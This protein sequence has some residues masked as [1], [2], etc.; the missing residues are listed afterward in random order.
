MI[1]LDI[2]LPAN[3][4]NKFNIEGN[5]DGDHR[6]GAAGNSETKDWPDLGIPELVS[7]CSLF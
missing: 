5:G 2:V 6:R 4:N 1:E 7:K 3:M